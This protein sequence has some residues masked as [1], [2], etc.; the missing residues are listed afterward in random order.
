MKY[1]MLI[2]GSLQN[3]DGEVSPSAEAFMEYHKAVCDAGI[4]VDSNVLEGIDIA[5]TVR[6]RGEE[7]IVTDGPYAETR[8][9]VGGYYVLELPDLDAALEWAGRN[10]GARYGRIEVRPVA[11]YGL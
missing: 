3:T 5:T 8:E 9:F 1:M 2:I 6:V 4:L 7:R 10:P 11:N